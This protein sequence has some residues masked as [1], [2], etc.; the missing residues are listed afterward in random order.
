[1]KITSKMTSYNSS[2]G[3]EEIWNSRR[4]QST[5]HQRRK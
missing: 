3:T 2:I 4:R 5:V 1:M